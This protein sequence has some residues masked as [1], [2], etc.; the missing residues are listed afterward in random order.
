MVNP[1]KCKCIIIPKNYP[2]DLSFSITYIQ[3]PFVDHL[4]RLCVTIDNSQNFIKHVGNG[5][6]S[7]FMYRT[8]PYTVHGGYQFFIGSG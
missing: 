5:N 3:V 8:Y 4:G 7:V 1:E 6:G 2:C